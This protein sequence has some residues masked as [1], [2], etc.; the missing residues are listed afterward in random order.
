MPIRRPA[1][2][3]EGPR[4][5]GPAA[6]WL[7]DEGLLE[8]GFGFCAT[9]AMLFSPTFAKAGPVLMSLILAA[10]ATLRPR[11]WIVGLRRSWLILA[12]PAVAL[13]SAFWSLHRVATLYYGTQYL[14]TILL[15]IAIGTA[16]RPQKLFLGLFAGFAV[17]VAANLVL[18]RSVGWE[19]RAGAAFGGLAGVKNYMGATSALGALGST[20]FLLR[21][22]RM[23]RWFLALGALA[24]L[25]LQLVSIRLA[26]ATG[27]ELGYAEGA[28]VIAA[29]VF[30]R[31]CVPLQARYGIAA[32]ATSAAVVALYFH[33]QLTDLAVRFAVTVL[34]KDVTLTG[35]T[36]L[37]AR[38]QQLIEARPGLGVGYAAFWRQGDLDAEGLWRSEDIASRAGFSFHNAPIGWMV[39]LGA[40]GLCVLA[41]VVAVYGAK[42]VI[43]TLREP[44]DVAV[45]W[46]AILTYLVASMGY[47]AIG[48]NPFNYD[49]ILLVA[50]LAYGGSAGLL[51]VKARARGAD[52]RLAQAMPAASA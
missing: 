44:D 2:R 5:S 8:V 22:A 45:F 11:D 51:G 20:V 47:E 19:G 9:V 17:C 42:L 32:A 30:A 15:A 1:T 24:A 6:H 4:Q 12:L 21:W 26:L 18:G 16:R 38:G 28:V 25:G 35:R 46:T 49:T 27:A 43:R 39:E 48:L 40:L 13:G 36:Y 33:R 23:G 3:A 50:A 34:H 52:T 29:L 31:Y 14:I 7:D 41:M 37:W 10:Y